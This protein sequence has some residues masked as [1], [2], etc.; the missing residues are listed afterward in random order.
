M[1]IFW[2]E[3]HSDTNILTLLFTALL[4]LYSSSK[5]SHNIRIRILSIPIPIEEIQNSSKNQGS[6]TTALR[7]S[8]G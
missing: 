6:L 7:S 2:R 5:I 4:L 8:Q 3:I 1:R